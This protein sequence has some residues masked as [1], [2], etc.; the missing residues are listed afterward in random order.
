MAGLARVDNDDLLVDLFGSAKALQSSS[1]ELQKM[2][3]DRGIFFG[4]G[5]LPTYAFAFIA[6]HERIDRWA[7][8]SELVIAG[9]DYLANRL[10]SDRKFYDAIG[11]SPDMFDLVSADPG[12]RR[13]CVI[14]RPDGIPSGDD[15]K[16]VELNC[17]SPAMMMFLDIVTQCVLELDAFA[18]LRQVAPP[19]TADRLLEALLECYR[20]YGGTEQPTIAITDWEGQKTRFEHLR[21]L[22]H[23][24][25][26]GYATVICDPR[27]FRRVEGK[28]HVNGRQVDLVYRRALVSEI[29]DH[30]DELD[31]LLGAYRDGTICMVNPLRSYVTSA[32]AVLSHLRELP[33]ELAGAADLV[34]R[35]LILDNDEAR[36]IVLASPGKW[37]LKKSESHGGMNVV[38]PGGPS[39]EAW[40]QAMESSSREVWIA[41]EYLEVPRMTLPVVEG[42]SVI[43]S[44]KYFNWNPFVFGGRYAGGLVR[45]SSTPLINICLGG[46][47]LPTLA[48]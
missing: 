4:D 7:A 46:G 19:S 3:R 32:K 37:A 33:P 25:A 14:C 5:L 27:A 40:R 28:L 2:L 23:F 45:V 43:W 6:P 31:A 18:T 36:A 42:E 47:L 30:R 10:I 24:E 48:T 16:F 21:L 8:H 9:A 41:Q 11:L 34:P 1:R 39:E 38:L 13:S 44:E 17:D 29:N 15:L 35:T 12:Y 22:E 26:R 20:E